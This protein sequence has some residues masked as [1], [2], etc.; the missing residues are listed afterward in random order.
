MEILVAGLAALVVVAL[1]GRALGRRRSKPLRQYDELAKR[2]RLELRTHRNGWGLGIGERHSLSGEV[3]GYPVSIYAHF[4]GKGRR[5][6]TWTSLAM[7]A[8]FAGELEL[9]VA[10]P[11]TQPSA[12]FAAGPELAAVASAPPGVEAWASEAEAAEI[13]DG[14]GAPEAL[15]RLAKRPA[16][17]A[18]CLSKGFFEYREVG[19]V[20]DDAGR[21]RFQEAMLALACLAD[22]AS[23]YAARRARA[24]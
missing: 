9:R 23:V 14:E 6:V 16:A 5:R 10:F 11:G 19:T 13:F 7:E 18:I 4:R 8:L 24:P 17:G 20:R 22:A 1:A 2:F 15:A 3:R 21:A 12:R